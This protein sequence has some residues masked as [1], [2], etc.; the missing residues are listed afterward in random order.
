MKESNRTM[1]DEFKTTLK[2]R[3]SK[4]ETTAQQYKGVDFALSELPQPV[5]VATT[6]A[7]TNMKLTNFFILNPPSLMLYVQFNCFNRFG[8]YVIIYRNSVRLGE[9]L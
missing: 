6:I 4:S 9:C 7:A 3:I 5:N 2:A 8:K 1:L